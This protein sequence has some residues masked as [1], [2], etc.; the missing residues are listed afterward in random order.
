VPRDSWVEHHPGSD[1]EEQ[2]Q[3]GVDHTSDRRVPAAWACRAR[4]VKRNSQVFCKLPRIHTTNTIKRVKLCRKNVPYV[5]AN[6]R[7]SS[8]P[9]RY[10]TSITVRVRQPV[11]KRDRVDGR[12]IDHHRQDLQQHSENADE[13][14]QQ[15][16]EYPHDINDKP[17][18]AAPCTPVTVALQMIAQP[19]R[20]PP[21]HHN[22]NVERKAKRRNE[23]GKAPP[24]DS[25]CP[26]AQR[27]Q[28]RPKV[29]S[30]CCMRL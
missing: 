24:I 12:K 3:H 23:N 25:N 22:K 9:P 30:Y 21:P 2:K 19:P 6:N 1:G 5:T 17:P 20:T 11:Q 14:T 7:Q 8:P 4:K 26:V 28:P 10:T 29:L 18:R 15:R 27:L 16:A 13:P